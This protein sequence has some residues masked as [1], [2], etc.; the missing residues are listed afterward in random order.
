[1]MEDENDELCLA[2]SPRTVAVSLGEMGDG[3]ADKAAAMAITPPR[4]DRGM[5]MDLEYSPRP[6][7]FASRNDE[8]EEEREPKGSKDRGKRVSFGE[9]SSSSS[10]SDG[11]PSPSAS[12]CAPPP[13]SPAGSI[14]SIVG[15]VVPASA[16]SAEERSELWWQSDDYD[17]FLGTARLISTEIQR[18]SY[19]ATVGNSYP[20]SADVGY[21]AGL[22]IVD[23]KPLPN[24]EG[25]ANVM[26]AT[27]EACCTDL[28]PDQADAILAGI[29]RRV[30]APKLFATLTHWVRVGHSRRG[31]ERWSVPYHGHGRHWARQRH[32]EAVLEAQRTVREWDLDPEGRG[33][34]EI[35]TVA[36]AL[37]RCVFPSV[38]LIWPSICLHICRPSLYVLN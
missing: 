37:S 29:S 21:G 34:S 28:D 32:L 12:C 11:T 9:A 24:P 35:R 2:S 26:S 4:K 14:A 15:Y 17:Q 6:P 25:Y 10:S 5:Q 27:L 30:L 13:S 7:I 3:L 22:G 31:L 19:V 23:V 16:L 20:T 8:S 1:M 33:A 18:R 38:L 36:A